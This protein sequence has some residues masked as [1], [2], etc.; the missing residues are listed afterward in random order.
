MTEYEMQKIA[1]MQASFL[2]EA[3]KKDDE[4]LDLM[5]PPKYMNI[6]EAAAYMRTTVGTIYQKTNEIPHTKVGRS[7]IFSE[8]ALSR[9][10]ERNGRISNDNDELSNIVKLKPLKVAAG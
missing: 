3:L 1:K 4:L 5:F 7:L 10:M 9:Y 8:R 6:Q 2:V